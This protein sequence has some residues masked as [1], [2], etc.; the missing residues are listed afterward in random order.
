MSE[1]CVIFIE[2]KENLFYFL[3]ISDVSDVFLFQNVIIELVGY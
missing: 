2:N 3:G 1:N